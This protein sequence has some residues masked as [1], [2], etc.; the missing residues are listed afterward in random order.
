MEFKEIV[1]ETD[2]TLL[3]PLPKIEYHVEVTGQCDRELCAIDA[4]NCYDSDF[5]SGGNYDRCRIFDVDFRGGLILRSLILRNGKRARWTT[6]GGAIYTEGPL[7]IIGS[8]LEANAATSGGGV[9]LTTVGRSNH[10]TLTI[11]NSSLINNRCPEGRGGSL[12]IFSE[13][14]FP[15]NLDILDTAFNNNTAVNGGAVL[16]LADDIAQTNR[17]SPGERVFW[18]RFERCSFVTNLAQESGGAFHVRGTS[19]A[20]VALSLA[21]STLDRNAASGSSGGAL[22]ADSGAADTVNTVH[23]EQ[24]LLTHNFALGGGGALHLVGNFGEVR[25]TSDETIFRSNAAGVNGA[26]GGLFMAAPEYDTFVAEITNSVFANNSVSEVSGLPAL[27]Q[28]LEL[29]SQD[30]G[31]IY[32]SG[33]SVTA[34]GSS[35]ALMLRR[36]TLRDNSAQ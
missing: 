33:K 28:R 18:G 2:I 14:Q 3:D 16:L 36:S 9:Y 20:G 34:S 12:F 32:L 13:Y 24:S 25:A 21:N 5:F 7:T 30:G 6:G 8:I 29:G 4:A 19:G 22:F 27:L 1:L 31:A 11:E 35:G 26:G 10:M 17:R 15:V 23:F